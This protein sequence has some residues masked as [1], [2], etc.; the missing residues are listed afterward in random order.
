MKRAT[1]Q[2]DSFAVR[3]PGRSDDQ[4]L[5]Q[6]M[7][8]AYSVERSVDYGTSLEDLLKLR[9]WVEAGCGWVDTALMLAD[10]NELR[11]HAA[12]QADQHR[13]SARFESFAAACCRLAQA[14]LESDVQRR[15]G[16]YERQVRSFQRSVSGGPVDRLVSFEITHRGKPHAAWLFRPAVFSTRTPTVVVWGGADGWCEAF[17]GSVPFYT[18]RG[19]AVCLVE[20]PGQGLAR[21]RHGSFLDANFGAFVSAAL[22]A[23]VAHGSDPDRFGVVGHSAGGTLAL[24]AAAADSRIRAC[25]TNGGSLQPLN[26]FRKYPRVLQ[27]FGRLTGGGCDESDMA[28][29]FDRLGLDNAPRKMQ[30]SLLCLQGGL[31]PLV[32]NVEAQR[33]VDLRGADATLAYWAEGVHCLYNHAIERNCVMAEWFATRLC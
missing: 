7:L 16:I 23:L 19:L 11:A 31:D 28:A 15:T 8:R 13:L 26:G 22:D 3:P 18:E 17:H 24:V 6:A 25:C 10:D 32:D 29:L 5:D 4:A 27:R 2:V 14:A 20:L 21:L 1:F 33:L 9:R 12:S 30:A